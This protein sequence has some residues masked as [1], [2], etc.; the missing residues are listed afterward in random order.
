MKWWVANPQ[1]LTVVEGQGNQDFVLPAGLHTVSIRTR[2]Q[3]NN[4]R[5][6]LS[7]TTAALVAG[8]DQQVRSLP[9]KI[10]VIAGTDGIYD[11]WSAG[12]W[13][14]RATLRTADGQTVLAYSD[15]GPG[16]W[17]FHLSRYL[18][19]GEYMLD[20][21]E[22]FRGSGVV[23]VSCQ[24]RE[25][26][27]V[28]TRTL[29]LSTRLS[30]DKSVLGIPFR[31]GPRDALVQI[32][33]DLPSVELAL[34]RDE[35]L[36]AVGR[37]TLA[38]PLLADRLYLLRVR[39]D[40][41]DAATLALDIQAPETR[42]LTWGGAQA[43]ALPAG[44][45]IV[46]NATGISAQVPDG[47]GRLLLSGAPERV[48]TEPK[49]GVIAAPRGTLWSWY[50]G[51]DAAIEPL[52]LVT[53]RPRVFDITDDDVSLRVTTTPDHV[54]VLEARSATG[55]LGMSDGVFPAAPG[56]RAW[57]GIDLA[58]SSSI[59]GMAGGA[60]HQ[61]WLW[62]GEP[63]VEGRRVELTLRAF[64]L[65]R[66]LSQADLGP[67]ALSPG[68]A[69]TVRAQ[70]TAALRLLLSPDVVAFAAPTGTTTQ[71]IAARNESRSADMAGGHLYVVNT[72]SRERVVRVE[73]APPR[74]PL[75]V[76][77]MGLETR[78]SAPGALSARVQASGGQESDLAVWAVEP[79]EVTLLTENG[80]RV[81]ARPPDA[82]RSYWLLP[83]VPGTL[84]VT[85]GAGPVVAWTGNGAEGLLAWASRGAGGAAPLVPGSN[86][87]K[88]APERWRFSLDRAAFVI[89]ATSN[90]GI[91]VL[92]PGASAGLPLYPA[93][94]SGGE[95][96]VFAALP[97][98]THA[99]VTRPFAGEPQPD[100][101]HLQVLDP[102]SITENEEP[103]PRFLAPGEWIVFE[104]AVQEKTPVG[105]GLEAQ[106]DE[107][108]TH[109]FDEGLHRL[110]SG[111]L[112]YREL[113]S[114]RYYFLVENGPHPMRVR[115]VIVA[116]QGSRR[117]V[118]ED[119]IRTYR[120]R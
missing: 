61:V 24:L 3:N 74:S 27:W 52:G 66:E 68:E 95:R 23:T 53:G 54:Y 10:P 34:Y 12:T 21:Q 96:T 48:A 75:T 82:A 100:A 83:G 42:S 37:D 51:E 40:D 2:E 46:A 81:V 29:P 38:V 79:T 32:T 28:E 120:E 50:E 71:T 76:A 93:L 99:V 103:A 39:N 35:T 108:T 55:Y 90:R 44:A 73:A 116:D 85:S 67:L 18:P 119:V 72:G 92:E 64:A 56:T 5:Y 105:I 94:G 80:R 45:V 60:T 91:T 4:V 77:A 101:L 115:P 17:N 22:S 102:V 62:D 69:V 87:M 111:R 30:L 57:S 43:L 114:G 104:V 41:T 31:T 47:L 86:P 84:R 112:F 70:D 98:G 107:Y 26:V 11:L 118:P 25:E 19:A 58:P 7:L 8:L 13:D 49:D 97:A 20:V 88:A 63:R 9:A 78:L 65:G 15:D 113:E 1:G 6:D 16:D 59:L 110:G 14:V 117:G 109:L 33:S 36:V 89:A 106:T